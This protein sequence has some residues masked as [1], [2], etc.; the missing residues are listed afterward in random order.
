MDVKQVSIKVKK[1][2]DSTEEP[3]A[4]HSSLHSPKRSFRR[5]DGE[6]MTEN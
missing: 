5:S 3:D 6:L 1:I 4:T 2:F